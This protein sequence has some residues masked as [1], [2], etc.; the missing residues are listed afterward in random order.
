MTVKNKKIRSMTGIGTARGQVGSQGYLVEARSV[1]NR[2][3]DLSV[4]L[5]NNWADLELSVKS[6]AQ[7]YFRRGKINISISLVSSQGSK[8]HLQINEKKLLQYQQDLNHLAKKMKLETLKMNDLLRLPQIFDMTLSESTEGTAWKELKK[9][10]DK[11]FEALVA[12]REKEGDNLKRDFL[13]RLKR[14]EQLMRLIDQARKNRPKDVQTKLIE[15]IKRL[16]ESAAQDKDRLARETAYLAEKSDISEEVVRFKSHLE[17][18]HKTLESDG[19]AGKKLDFILQELNREAN[20]IA[21]KSGY[22]KIS[23]NVIEIKSEI[24]KIREQVQNIE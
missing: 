23:K 2:Y 10:L 7:Q 18:F 3:L 4:R 11:A 6:L 21:S 14:L 13:K 24:E 8:N 12:S 1:N 16:S 20:T 9:L 19:E 22:F 5:P 15:K 17:L